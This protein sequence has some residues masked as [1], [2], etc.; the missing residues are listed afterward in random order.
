MRNYF[1]LFN[2][3]AFKTFKSVSY[4]VGGRYTSATIKVH[5]ESKGSKVLMVFVQSVIER[6]LWLLV[7]KQ[8]K[9][10]V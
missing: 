7:V 4:C 2:K 3:W 9:Q 6:N 8:S 1:Y 5:G 10:K